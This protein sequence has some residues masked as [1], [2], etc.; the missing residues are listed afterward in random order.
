MNY[1]GS[2]GFGQ[3]LVEGLCGRVGTQDV[4]DV[5]VNPISVL[6]NVRSCLSACSIYHIPNEVICLGKLNLRT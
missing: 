6:C 1:R 4:K 5:Q 3:S 2:I